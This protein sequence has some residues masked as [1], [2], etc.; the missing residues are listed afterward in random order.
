MTTNLRSKRQILV[1]TPIYPADDIPKG[2][3]PVVHYFTR[4]WVKMG[5]EVHVINYVANFPKPVYWLSRFFEKSI[6]SKV[7]YTIRT[8]TLQDKQYELEGV[9]VCRI[10]LK[11]ARPHTRYSHGQIKQAIRKTLEYCESK[12]I[13]PSAIISHWED[14]SLE[15][16][17]ELKQHFHVPT[18]Y[19]AHGANHFTKYGADAEKFWDAVDIVGY[20]SDYIKK[21]FESE[22]RFVKPSFYCYSG[23]PSSYN[24]NIIAR[25]WNPINRVAY[26]GTLIG[27]KF[28]S[29]LVPALHHVF[30][31]GFTLKYAGE[32]S[33]C[34]RIMQVSRKLGVE[35]NVKLLG[36]INRE[37]VIR[38]MD[39]SDLFI[40]ISKNETFGLV[41]LEAMARGCI[42][43][44]SRQ[45][46]FD[47]II[48]HGYNGFLCEA[49]NEEEL[50]EILNVIKAMSPEERRII[51]SRGMETARELTD[52]KVAKDYI[53]HV[54]FAK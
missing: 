48:R 44:A 41:Y 28:P 15:I 42:V 45:E 13:A 11:K 12:R 21:K 22:S 52:E 37:D 16:M 20:R 23:I 46:G 1:L 24:E 26:V 36:R 33:E 40:M 29:T 14:P 43:I 9:H 4:E 25:D 31:N 35:D 2:W 34:N 38:L 19:V 17:Y 10:M 39:E 6:S 30:K 18:C 3:T 7:G 49:G 47:G 50:A 53:E 8:T 51:S 32:G 5:Y 54:L 27:R